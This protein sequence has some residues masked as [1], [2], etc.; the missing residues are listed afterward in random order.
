MEQPHPF[1][2]VSVTFNPEGG[3]RVVWV[4][5]NRFIDPLPHT[6]QLQASLSSAA[7]ATDYVDVGL[8]V[9]NSFY[10]VDDAR[11][12][13]GKTME[14]HYRVKVTTPEGTFTSAPVSG[15]SY[16]NKREWLH[17]RD[18][19]RQLK[20]LIKKY[21]GCYEGY[22]LKRKRFGPLCTRCNN[23]LTDEPTDSKCPICFGT[24]TVAG[25]FAAIPDFHLE[26][27]LE[28]TREKVELQAQGTT[29]PL[30]ITGFCAA[31]VLINSRD[32]FISQRSG[33]RWFIETVKTVAEYRGYPTKYE[34]ELR[35]APFSDVI[36]KVPL[37]G[38]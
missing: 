3:S 8:P 6:Y 27:G 33:R 21:T 34:L 35:V 37:E 5:S 26:L 14:V 4:M 30:V 9:S 1:K 32:V 18:Q 31:D 36:Y 15:L 17:A 38:S 10:A 16:H 25:Y 23:R 28:Q 12:L 22:L 20:K 7:T 19:I 29:K 24:G 2:Q 11:R 13:T